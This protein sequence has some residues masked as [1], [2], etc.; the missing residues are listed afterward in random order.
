MIGGQGVLW[1]PLTMTLPPSASRLLLLGG[2]AVLLGVASGWGAR[3]MARPAV[4]EAPPLAEMV[5]PPPVKSS[6]TLGVQAP[7]GMAGGGVGDSPSPAGNSTVDKMAAAFQA[8]VLRGDKMTSADLRARVRFILAQGENGEGAR[9]LAGLLDS[10]ASFDFLG[11]ESAETAIRDLRYEVLHELVLKADEKTQ[12]FLVQL[13]NSSSNLREAVYIA[14]KLRNYMRGDEVNLPRLHQLA[15]SSLNQPAAS[16]ETRVHQVTAA[17]VVAVYFGAEDLL[18]T[19][20]AQCMA[21]REHYKFSDFYGN[22][23]CRMPSELQQATLTRLGPDHPLVR[24][25]ARDAHKLIRLDI[26][27]PS[28]QQLI[29]R[30]LKEAKTFPEAKKLLDTHLLGRVNRNRW[31]AMGHDDNLPQ[32]QEPAR[33]GAADFM[34]AIAQLPD[35]PEGARELAEKKVMSLEKK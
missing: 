18:P 11:T 10:T 34:R 3:E 27:Q 24:D 21:L 2:L 14:D 5:K 9:A 33:P 32:G 16:P 35:L 6:S 20:E 7:S 26:T 23:L 28:A 13:S 12:D 15:R 22:V 17:A 25:M 19:V 8:E 4:V 1:Y 30:Y 29:L 31:T